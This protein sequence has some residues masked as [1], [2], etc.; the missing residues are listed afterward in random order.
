MK[1][2][3]KIPVMALASALALGSLA[4]CYDLTEMNQDPYALPNN[5]VAKPKPEPVEPKG[6]YGDID[7]SYEV[8][9]PEELAQIKTDLS[10]APATFRNFLYEGYY[11]DYQITTNLTHDIY[12]GYTGNNKP[13]F[14]EI[15]RASCRE[16][17]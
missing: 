10:A 17:V 3:Y 15:G 6:E 5:A 13:N 7:I 12:S 2:A 9:D 1:T 14:V 11:N 16:R 8:T 4:S